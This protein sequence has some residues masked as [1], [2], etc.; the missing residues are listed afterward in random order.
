MAMY[1]KSSTKS[2]KKSTKGKLTPAIRKARKKPGGSNVGEYPNETIFAGPAGGAP[3]RSFPL[4]KN[5]KKNIG[6]GRSAIKLAHNAP[7]PQGIKNKVYKVF[8]SLK[9]KRGVKK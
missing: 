7:R 3:A 9:P 6:R 5:G 1:K 2:P 8:P 4:T